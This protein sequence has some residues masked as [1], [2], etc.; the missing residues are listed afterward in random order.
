MPAL[1][2]ASIIHANKIVLSGLCLTSCIT[3]DQL[4]FCST[5]MEM[6][7]DS[8]EYTANNTFHCSLYFI[9]NK[10]VVMAFYKRFLNIAVMMV[11][12]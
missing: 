11:F 6:K 12:H 7:R 4:R 10:S 8:E 1:H 2:C 5:T 9:S 3:N